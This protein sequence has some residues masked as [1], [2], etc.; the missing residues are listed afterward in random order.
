[1][2]R[3]ELVSEDK[4]EEM[5][6]YLN[7][8]LIE[9]SQFDNNISFDGDKPIYKWFDFYWNDKGRYPYYFY[10]DNEVAGIS[11]VR[12]VSEEKYEIAE[13]Y[14]LPKFRGGGNALWFAGEIANKFVG[15]IDFST[16]HKNIRAIKFWNKFA[17]GFVNADVIEDDEWINWE[18]RKREPKV[19]NSSLQHRFFE[20]ISVGEKILEGRLND[21]KRKEIK[22]DDY[23]IFN[24]LSNENN[25]IKVKVVDKYYFDNFDQMTLFIDK[26]QLGFGKNESVDDVIKL[27][28]SIYPKEKED[29]YG[30]VIFK[31]ELV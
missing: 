3:V 7:D 6:C 13:F 20:S 8:Y 31:I 30:V 15:E 29:K 17:L 23:I 25:E 26:S 19:F 27:Y 1:M 18:I 14:V 16:R 2:R 22:I 21:D 5:R 24:D 28:R 10:I 12:E 11:F 9:L 4:K